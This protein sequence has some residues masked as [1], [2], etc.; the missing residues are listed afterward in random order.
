MSEVCVRGPIKIHFH[1]VLKLLIRHEEGIYI[2][3][4]I[5]MEQFMTYYAQKTRC[6]N[7]C[8][9]RENM[10]PF[11]GNADDATRTASELVELVQHSSKG[12]AT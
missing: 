2:A 12:G 9:G 6:L 1:L 8:K 4:M 11:A 3:I 5:T 10:P 7:V